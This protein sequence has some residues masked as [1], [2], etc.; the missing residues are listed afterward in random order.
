MIGSKEYPTRNFGID[1]H[2]VYVALCE[3]VFLHSCIGLYWP[4]F[5]AVSLSQVFIWDAVVWS[6][7]IFSSYWTNNNIL[8]FLLY[9]DSRKV[10]F[11]LLSDRSLLVT[12]EEVLNTQS[13]LEGW[14]DMTIGYNFDL[15]VNDR[16]V[17]L[18]NVP[19]NII[20]K[21]LANKLK[22]IP[23]K[24]QVWTRLLLL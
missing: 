6:C 23:Q 1:E 4:Y 13:M 15:K 9:W 17:S 14:N 12:P 22:V 11:S 5:P 21:V 18:C 8:F 2:P 19:Y 16:T 10:C 24:I 7:I 3:S 20:S